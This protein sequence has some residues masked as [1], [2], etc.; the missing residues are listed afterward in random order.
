VLTGGRLRA[1]H[2]SCVVRDGIRIILQARPGPKSTLALACARRGW[3]LLAEDVV[4][5]RLA[6]GPGVDSALELWGMP[7]TQ[8]LLPDATRFF[9]GL[10]SATARLQANGE[11][12][13]EIDLDEHAPGTA[14]PQA[15][16][17][18]IV[19]LAR[20]S[21]G[22][23]RAE[24]LS[25]LA[26]PSEVETWPWELGWTAAHE[27]TAAR[28]LEHG[29]LRLHLNSTPDEAVTALEA[30]LEPAAAR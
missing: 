16:A 8:R 2:A 15:T 25:P 23:T 10:G 9:P 21:G 20:D 3:G 30:A 17:G 5:V 1:I 26:A 11:H 14:T 29:V 24:W 22:P 18:P 13:L 28:L 4:F 27:Q 19:L 7:W 6:P 12:K